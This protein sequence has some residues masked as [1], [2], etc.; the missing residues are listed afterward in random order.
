MQFN[1]QKPVTALL[2]ITSQWRFNKQQFI[3]FINYHLIIVLLKQSP[4][5]HQVHF[6]AGRQAST[7][8]AQR[9]ERAASQLSRFHPKGPVASKFVG[10]EPNGLSRVGCN[11]GGL[12]LLQI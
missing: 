12:G 2:P 9:T 5:A 7:H 10:Y 8:S 1:F 4:A 11:V 3:L 6:P